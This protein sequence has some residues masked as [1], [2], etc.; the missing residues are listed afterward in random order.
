MV[1][2]ILRPDQL[3]SKTQDFIRT[4]M[5]VKF[6][7]GP[8][9]DL[10]SIFHFSSNANPIILLQTP[11]TDPAIEYLRVRSSNSHVN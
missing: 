10:A 6:V 9:T 3:V 2:R 11:G 7:E 8:A 4:K 5:G 1:W